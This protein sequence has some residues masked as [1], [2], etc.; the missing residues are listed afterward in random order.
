MLVA[1]VFAASEVK[2]RKE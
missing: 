1:L 2:L